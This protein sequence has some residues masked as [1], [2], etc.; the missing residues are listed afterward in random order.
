MTAV[1]LR[2]SVLYMPGSNPRALEKAKTLAA[3]CLIFD[4]EDAVAPEAKEM[5][6]E[7]VV[8]AVKAGGYGE[9]ELIVRI[10]GLTTPW[11]AADL[12]AAAGA[13]ADA[14][15]LPKVQSPADT[16]RGRR[17]LSD[18]AAAP[19]ALWAM[20]ETPLAMLNAK[21]IA[22]AAAS[23]LYPLTAF[24]LGTNDLSKETRAAQ[25]RDRL[26]ML[27]W[28]SGCVAAAR[29]FGLAILDGVFNAIS[30]QAGFAAECEQGR[31]L[32]MD[33]KTLIHPSQI[34]PCNAI[35]SPTADEVAWARKILAAFALPE[36]KGKGAIGVDGRMVELQHAE[37][38]AATV[39][40]AEAI[41]RKD[42][43]S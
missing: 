30:D 10:N 42:K 32:G 24:V 40:A 21:D 35:F 38:A 28:L 22:A 2:R 20:M 37:I 8:A 17:M 1:R 27:T 43:P 23:D 5:A 14:I 26:P 34:G 25:T 12:R 4:L 16:E 36:N 19:V 3:D 29:A 39:A 13:G 33:G 18:I 15:L 7:Q 11:G 6:R 9:R 31:M 41:A